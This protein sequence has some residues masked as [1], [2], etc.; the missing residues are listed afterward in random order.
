MTIPRALVRD[1]ARWWIVR[2]DWLE[3]QRTHSRSQYRA[4][5]QVH[6][7]QA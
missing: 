4:D 6:E 1:E 7:A 3:R 5:D 2:V